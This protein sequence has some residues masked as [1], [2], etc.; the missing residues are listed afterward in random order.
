MPRTTEN[1]SIKIPDF[2]K[3]QNHR[4]KLKVKRICWPYTAFC[5]KEKKQKTLTLLILSQLKMNNSFTNFCLFNVPD[6]FQTSKLFSQIGSDPRTELVV[7]VLE[8][9]IS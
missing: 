8:E 4:S 3:E 9:D 2:P 1:W 6:L 5:K 7:H